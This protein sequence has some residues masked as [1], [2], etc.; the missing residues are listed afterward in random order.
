VA[1]VTD[2]ASGSDQRAH[3]R[4]YFTIDPAKPIRRGP[5]VSYECLKCG[6]LVPS[7]EEVQG[8]WHC[9]CYA[10]KVDHD[11]FRATFREPSAARGVVER[12]EP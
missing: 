2:R 3:G 10:I 9:R 7:T 4:Q 11:A 12:K 6:D 1:G 8:P 5:D